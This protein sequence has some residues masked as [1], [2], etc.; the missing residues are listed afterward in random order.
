MKLIFAALAGAL[1]TASSA[2][3]HPPNVAHAM[4]ARA[5][6]AFMSIAGLLSRRKAATPKAVASMITPAQMVFF[7][8]TLEAIMPTGR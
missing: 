5:N 3:A 4:P 6:M 2:G 8:P 7:R 1:L